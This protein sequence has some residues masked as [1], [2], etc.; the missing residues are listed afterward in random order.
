MCG[1]SG[2]INLSS[3]AKRIEKSDIDGLNRAIY[4]QKHR[5][6]DDTGICAFDFASQSS[7]FNQKDIIGVG[8]KSGIS[9]ILGFNRLSIK[10]LSLAGHQPMS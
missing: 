2:I 8:L 6:P 5:G 1:I 7:Y 3:S 9:G 10:D 4:A